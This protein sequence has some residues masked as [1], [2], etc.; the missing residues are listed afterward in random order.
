MISA[1]MSILLVS[2]MAIN[3][4]A[5][6]SAEPE[7][8]E[9][10]AN[11]DVVHPDDDFE[12]AY[13][14]I[15]SI[16]NRKAVTMNGPTLRKLRSA[17][18]KLE[19][20]V[21]TLQ[22]QIADLQKEVGTLK[23]NAGLVTRVDALEL[24][25]NGNATT[26]GLV[27][28]MQATEDKYNG[29]EVF[30]AMMLKSVPTDGCATVKQL[31]SVDYVNTT[32]TTAKSEGL[33]E[34]KTYVD[35]EVNKVKDVADKANTGVAT[36]QATAETAQKTATDARGTA[37]DAANRAE[38]ANQKADATAKAVVAL[39]YD[40]KERGMAG[41]Y[42]SC[43]NNKDVKSFRDLLPSAWDDKKKTETIK[44]LHAIAIKCDLISSKSVV[45][46]ETID[47]EE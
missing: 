4:Y 26:S 31:A 5:Q 14:D 29:F 1:V 36:A 37:N 45:S 25:V 6:Q 44:K 38:V 12:W 23:G 13:N 2:M 9:S 39:V 42:A 33:A 22:R 43:Y 11:F 34:G 47:E 17:D 7:P 16:I 40:K 8:I 41:L 10:Y 19:A 18:S 27:Q 30:Q 46:N 15:V 21:K 32:I 20:S 3:G 24:T 28:R 35:Q